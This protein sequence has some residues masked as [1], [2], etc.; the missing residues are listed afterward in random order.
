MAER[1]KTAAAAFPAGDDSVARDI[2]E[3]LA[4]GEARAAPPP[5]ENPDGSITHFM[6]EGLRAHTV[7]A[8]NPRLPDFVRQAET[9]VEPASFI[10]YVTQFKS[11]TAICRASLGHNRIEAV[12]DYHGRARETGDG[13]VP[14]RAAHSVTLL[15]PFDVDYAKWR[16][17][18]GRFLPQ[19]KMIAFIEEMIHT[20]A[21][22]PAAD[23]LEAMADIQIER[24]VRFKS[25]RNDRNGNIRFTYEEQDDG[26]T[27]RNGEFSLPEHVEI[28][29]PIFQGGNPQRLTAK[30]RHRMDKG[31]LVL[32]LAVPGLENIER[33]AFRAIGEDVRSKT[34]TPVFYV[35]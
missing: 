24:L 34:A 29:V 23:L 1:T 18:L 10:D 9:V 19:E 14:G 11:S 35:A 26:G 17:V 25:A 4:I 30:L 20:V 22:P 6:A 2:A 15:C 5:R 21:A 28:V 16:G 12:L 3:I 31:D 27:T 32:S 7:P 8:L 33:E 13:A